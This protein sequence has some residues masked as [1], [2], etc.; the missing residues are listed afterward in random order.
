[1][2][3]FGGAANLSHFVK[4]KRRKLRASKLPRYMQSTDDLPHLKP[5]STFLSGFALRNM[6]LKDEVGG[7]RWGSGE[8]KKG[9]WGGVVSE[10][11]LIQSEL[12]PKCAE[13]GR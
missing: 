7:V 5:G 9:K 8:E 2:G 12:I 6:A 3:V 10:W 1:M 4:L 13:T 11:H